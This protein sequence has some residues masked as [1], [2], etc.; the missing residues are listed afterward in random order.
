MVMLEAMAARKAIVATP[1][2]EN[3]RIIENGTDGLLVPVGDI[4]E[5]AATLDSVITDAGLRRR[6]GEA[7]RQKVEAQFTL[8]HMTRAYERLYLEI[9]Q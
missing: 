2:G 4:D 6:L 7:A 3:S 9:A 1:V 8:D 5:M